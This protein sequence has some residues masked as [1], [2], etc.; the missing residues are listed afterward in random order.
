MP[1]TNAHDLVYTLGS[2]RKRIKFT[3]ISNDECQYSLTY[4]IDGLVSISDL[5]L[6]FTAEQVESY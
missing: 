6:T 4:G 1:L 3:G 5:G 2:P